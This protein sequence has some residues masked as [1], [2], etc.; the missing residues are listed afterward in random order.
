[1][2]TRLLFLPSLLLA[3]SVAAQNTNFSAIDTS[4]RIQSI[5]GII[6][7][8]LR[9]K[10]A[11]NNLTV[12]KKDLQV[13]NFGQDMPTL[14]EFT[15]SVV[16]TCDAGAGIGYSG[17]RI[18]GVDASRI[19]VTI[20]GVPV[21]DPESHDV[22]WVNMPDLVG[23]IESI[24]IQRGVGSSTNG[25]AAFG[26]SVNIK[27]ND[28]KLQ[29]FAR[30]DLSGGSFGTLRGTL[31]A[32]T[33]L[34]KDRFSLEARLSEIRSDGYLD[35]ASS[36]LR[37]M[38]LTAS[39]FANKSVWKAVVL[40]GA[41]RTYQA[42]YGTPE[43]RYRGDS[44]G[45]LDYAA[46]NG[47]SAAETQNLLESGRTYNYY[48]Y[49][50]QVDNYKQDNYQ[51]HFIH[52]FSP[53][54]ELNLAGHYT[55]G[56]GYYEEFRN[57]D[58]LAEYGLEPVVVGSDS[59]L[60]TDLIRR[61]WL[62]NH[63]VGL[64]YGLNYQ[65]KPYLKF[66]FG[67]AANQYTGLHFGEIIWAEFASNSE[68]YDRY[69]ENDASKSEL[70]SY[71]KT[72]YNRNGLDLVLDLQYRGIAYQFLGVDQVSGNLADVTQ[73]VT[74][75]FFNPKV[76]FA[77]LLGPHQ[78]FGSFGIANREPVRRDFRESTPENRP[79]PERMFD[80]ELAYRLQFK[81]FNAQANLFW[82]Y[83]HDQLVLTGQI[84]DVGGYTRTNVD[85]SYRAGLE[86]EMAYKLND[87]FR[88]QSATTLSQNK[89]LNFVE[90]ID[91]YLD[92]APYYT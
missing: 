12:T 19:N 13:K 36:D 9:A 50:N 55:Y 87:K 38:G 59:I 24:Q 33:G 25:A 6:V 48:T 54:L 66:A 80:T 2:K 84:N 52:R 56:R 79:T 92:E 32:G 83:Y 43:S 69:Y 3:T 22:Y 11:P 73:Q 46:R 37:S 35:R 57:Q 63:F 74:Y 70:S 77:K 82:M 16:T 27:T 71:L 31:L 53:K 65:W 75:H 68:I 81:K 26:A 58:D 78:L 44:L 85:R 8:G 34:L 49:A 28:L 72:S 90:F 61:R 60:S 42:W 40:T 62:D 23:S 76:A 21:N 14:L 1:M 47:L 51:L 17:L 67:G 45:M 4:K 15:P 91:V 10:D 18:R 39:Y 64:V 29:P 20:N 88:I 30:M 7:S 89:I 5:E 41:E 86:L